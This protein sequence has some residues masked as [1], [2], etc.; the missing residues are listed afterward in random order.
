MKC[1]SVFKEYST[2][3]NHLRICGKIQHPI[4]RP[5]TFFWQY[6]TSDVTTRGFCGKIQHSTLLPNTHSTN[7][8]TRYTTVVR[9][10]QCFKLNTFFQKPTARNRSHRRT[11]EL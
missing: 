7:Y 11:A 3:N 1:P 9:S 6:S 4:P 10:V 2:P 8:R 5:R